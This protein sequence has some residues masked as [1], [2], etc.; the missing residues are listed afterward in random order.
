MTLTLESSTRTRDAKVLLNGVEQ[1]L[2]HLTTNVLDVGKLV[3]IGVHQL[4]LDTPVY[5]AMCDP[6]NGGAYRHHAKFIERRGDG[7]CIRTADF[8]RSAII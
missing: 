6:Y 7:L 2:K 5:F 4:I 3:D 8:L 1:H